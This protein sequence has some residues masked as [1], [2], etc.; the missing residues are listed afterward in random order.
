MPDSKFTCASCAETKDLRTTHAGRVRGTRIFC[1]T[2]IV[3]LNDGLHALW[4]FDVHSGLTG[5][6][7][8]IAGAFGS[9]P[10]DISMDF[11]CGIAGVNIVR[12][13]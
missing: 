9:N 13:Q 5:I 4:A 6:Q 12:F 1:S 2:C 3:R 8:H 7:R 10:F 11:S